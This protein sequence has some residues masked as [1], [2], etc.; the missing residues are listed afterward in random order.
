M[1]VGPEDPLAQGLAN[2]LTAAGIK[3]GMGYGC[4]LVPIT[5]HLP[6]TTIIE[7]EL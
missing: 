3:V 1:V 2:S 6:Y 4:P 5:P 7:Y